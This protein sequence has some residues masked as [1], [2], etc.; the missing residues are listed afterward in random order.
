VSVDVVTFGGSSSPNGYVLLFEILNGHLVETQEFGYNAQAPGTGAS[1]DTS[2]GKLM[3]TGRSDDGTPNCCPKKLDVANFLWN[4][5]R[6]ET[7]GYRA[8]PVREK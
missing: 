8:E 5:S 4:A 2:T 1:F 3:I 6:F 7:L